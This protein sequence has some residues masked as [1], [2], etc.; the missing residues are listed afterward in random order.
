MTDKAGHSFWGW[1][2]Q[3]GAGPPDEVTYTLRLV[4]DTVRI[5]KEPPSKHDQQTEEVSLIVPLISV[6]ALKRYKGAETRCSQSACC[7]LGLQGYELLRLQE[8][9]HCWSSYSDNNP[10]HISSWNSTDSQ[11]FSM[12]SLVSKTPLE[13][14]SFVQSQECNSSLSLAYSKWVTEVYH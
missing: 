4:Q 6:W 5:M 1:T 7:I 10:H 11:P 9:L 13:A 14:H 3:T 8:Q 12:P 2:F